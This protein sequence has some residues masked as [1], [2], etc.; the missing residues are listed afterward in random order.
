MDS[1]CL[2]VFIGGDLRRRGAGLW[3]KGASFPVPLGASLPAQ[4]TRLGSPLTLLVS[5]PRSMDQ[6][7][8][9][10]E[11][12]GPVTL[13]RWESELKELLGSGVSRARRCFPGACGG[14]AGRVKAS[15]WGISL[16]RGKCRGQRESKVVLERQAWGP[17]L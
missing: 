13:F 7:Y 11:K 14:A 3:P 8:P 1:R 6:G 5:A 17:C 16:W 9:T 4:I 10:Q 12:A 2:P 15:G